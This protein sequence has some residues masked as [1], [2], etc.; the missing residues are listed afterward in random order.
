MLSWSCRRFRARFVPG[1]P[2]ASVHPHRRACRECD[3]FAAALETA[4]GVRLPLP[5]G[6][7]KELTKIAAPGEGSVLAFPVP[8]LPMPA[9]LAGRLSELGGTS[10]PAPPDWVL[11]PRYAIAASALLA[12]LLGPFFATAADR[13]HEAMGAVREEVSP[14]LRHTGE[15]GRE[16]LGRLR[17]QALKTYE[18][19]RDS[20]AE[21]TEP[22]HGLS[23]RLL[24][25][26]PEDFTNPDP[27]EEESDGS[28]RRPQ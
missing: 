5:A 12:L 3:A 4:A 1:T 2:S 20:L 15:E 21:S 23:S 19:A 11:D 25:L 13:G 22:L 7:R 10:R 8:R 17:D 28:S 9:A 16:E 6:L 27:W 26:I 18:Q 24:P 14:L